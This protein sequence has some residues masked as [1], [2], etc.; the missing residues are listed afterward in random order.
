MGR[1]AMFR[2][3]RIPGGLDL[4]VAVAPFLFGVCARGFWTNALVALASRWSGCVAC[5]GDGP[6]VGVMVVPALMEEWQ[7]KESTPGLRFWWLQSWLGCG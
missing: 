7:C 5:A 3:Q 2:P 4:I 6:L 1:W